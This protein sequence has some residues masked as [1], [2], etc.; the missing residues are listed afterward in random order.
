MK[1]SIILTAAGDTSARIGVLLRAAKALPNAKVQAVLLGA[2]DSQREELIRADCDELLFA[3]IASPYCAESVLPFLQTLLTEENPSLVLFGPDASGG[4][5]APRLAARLNWP[6]QSGVSA[7]ALESG[8]LRIVRGAYNRNLQGAFALPLPAVL[9]LAKGSFEPLPLLHE[10]RAA[11]R[12]VTCKKREESWH[13]E[14]RIQPAEV[15]ND[16]T[17]A[18]L[19]VVGGRGVGSRANM[20]EL[21]ALAGELHGML[22]LTRPAAVDGW[23]KHSA[24]I[25]ISGV[26]VKPELCLVLGA[27]GASAFLS[28]VTGSKTLIAVNT[29]PSAAIFRACDIGIV[30][31]CMEFARA[32]RDVLARERMN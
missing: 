32:L 10:P 27:S 24:H 6:C 17:T 11:L 26:L 25:G 21:A 13:G 18:P 12:S 15:V 1:V 4:E 30:G 9:I 19:I 2:P 20:E 8:E 7:L 5:L 22:G 31:D 3:D 28:G 23:G 16:L 14:I 29:D